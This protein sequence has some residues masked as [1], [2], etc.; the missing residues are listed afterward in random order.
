MFTN[1]IFLFNSTN[2]QRREKANDE[3]FKSGQCFEPGF[4]VHP[5]EVAGEMMQMR[6]ATK[7]WS[8]YVWLALK[9][10]KESD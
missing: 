7:I 3:L 8:V 9:K 1:L 2:K 10:P 4:G 5:I 6:N